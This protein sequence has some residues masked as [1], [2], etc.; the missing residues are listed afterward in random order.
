MIRGYC[1]Q[2]DIL[3]N[4]YMAIVVAIKILFYFFQKVEQSNADYHG[5]C[6]AMC[7]SCPPVTGGSFLITRYQSLDLSAR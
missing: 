5:D 7:V 3:S 6:M 4:E 1:Y 2:F